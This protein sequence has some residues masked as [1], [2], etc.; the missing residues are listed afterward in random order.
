NNNVIGGNNK[1]LWKMPADMKF[2]MN[3]TK[4]HSVI[5]GRKTYESFGK[6]LKERR[7]IIITR[8]KTYAVEGCEIVHSLEAALDL[9]KGENEVF[10]IGGAEIYKQSMSVANKIYLTRIYGDFEGDAYFPD[11]NQENWA[12]TLIS[13]HPADE[14]NP[15]PFAFLEYIKK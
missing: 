7:N 15:Y 12:I 6:P 1:L 13:E 3:L 2:F 14:K 9:V 10:I 11:I 4:H 8:D 5:M